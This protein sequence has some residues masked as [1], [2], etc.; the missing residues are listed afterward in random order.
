MVDNTESTN[1]INVAGS[2]LFA[3]T[4]AFVK[5][6]KFG[7]P[8]TVD[9]TTRILEGIVSYKHPE[10]Y[11]NMQESSNPADI[12]A[13]EATLK[14]K[15]TTETGVIAPPTKPVGWLPNNPVNQ[16]DAEQSAS[17]ATSTETLSSVYPTDPDKQPNDPNPN[18]A[19][20]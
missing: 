10:I 16:A 9:L 13:F 8:R 17:T 4:D 19:K 20:P 7:Q 1:Q 15:E 3:A 5:R 11:R 6:S 12:A 2:S 18:K 14:L